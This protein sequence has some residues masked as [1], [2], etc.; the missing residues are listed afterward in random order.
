MMSRAMPGIVTPGGDSALPANGRVAPQEQR[1]GEGH[2]RYLGRVDALV[3]SVDERPWLLDAQQDELSVGVDVGERGAQRDRTTVS[4][5]PHFPADGSV[6]G[7]PQAL[8]TGPADPY[9]EVT[10]IGLHGV[11]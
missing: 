4:H 7:R 9:L 8:V 5:R 6:H 3:G 1:L 11:L 10:T 2:R